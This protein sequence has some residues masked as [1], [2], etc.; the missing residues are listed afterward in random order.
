MPITKDSNNVVLFSDLLKIYLFKD[1]E[2][3]KVSFKITDYVVINREFS[4]ENF[5]YILENWK[6][7]EGVQKLS[8]I[9]DGHIWWFHG[10]F[11]PRPECVPANFVSINFNRY[12]FRISVEEMERITENY[13]YQ[14]SNKMH[15]D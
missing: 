14:K 5:E 10:R 8:T 11:G 12:S 1:K 13:Y 7:G 6:I 4:Q 3:V 2:R 9:G 15:W